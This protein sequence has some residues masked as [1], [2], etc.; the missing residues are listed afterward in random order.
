MGVSTTARTP[1]A[2][3]IAASARTTARLAIDALM[4]AG[5][6]AQ[7][8]YRRRPSV[9]EKSAPPVR[10]SAAPR[11]PPAGSPGR[12]PARARSPSS[13]RASRSR[14][15][16][17]G[18]RWPTAPPRSTALNRADRRHPHPGRRVRRRRAAGL[19][20][21]RAAPRPAHRDDGVKPVAARRESRTPPARPAARRRGRSQRLAGPSASP[22]NPN[23]GIGSCSTVSHPSAVTAWRIPAPVAAMPSSAPRATSA[24]SPSAPRMTANSSTSAPGSSPVQVHVGARGEPRLQRRPAQRLDLPV[25]DGDRTP[26]RVH[27]GEH[28]GPVRGFG[29]RSAPAARG[30]APSALSLSMRNCAEATTSS[31]GASPWTISNSGRPRRNRRPGPVVT[32]RGMNLPS[33]VFRIARSARGRCGSAASLGTVTR[34]AR[35]ASGSRG[36]GAE[37]VGPQQ[38]LPVVEAQADGEGARPGVELGI[39]VVDLSP[40]NTRPGRCSNR[41]RTRQPVSARRGPRRARTR[42]PAATPT[43]GRPASSPASRASGTS[44]L[45]RRAP[46]PRAVARGA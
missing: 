20:F 31:P 14:P 10:A 30:P 16:G 24:S 9:S 3:S 8:P 23:S 46:S 34:L 36:R 27:L 5:I 40:S 33:P 26:R 29:L 42:R 41:A 39:D 17:R 1:A 6:T 11:P 35:A 7:D 38:P 44:R 12:G 15:A 28:A 19:R 18:L 43:T 2:A 4:T 37:H 45:R 25:A 13:C 22:A 32:S 21:G